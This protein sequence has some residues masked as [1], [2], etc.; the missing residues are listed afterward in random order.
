MKLKSN[1]SISESGFVFDAKSGESFSLNTTGLEIMNLLR[2]G[3]SEAE[4]KEFALSKYNV[5]EASFCRQL[6]D[7]CQMLKHF[8]LMENE[9]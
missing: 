9:N 2:E 8:N 7:Y 5:S 6:D 4:I 3:R 1:I